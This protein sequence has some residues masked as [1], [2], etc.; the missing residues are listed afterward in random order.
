[1][2]GYSLQEIIESIEFIY[3]EVNTREYGE[4][5]VRRGHGC[6]KMTHLILFMMF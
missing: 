5:S 1:M 6:L 2:L 4:N 3:L